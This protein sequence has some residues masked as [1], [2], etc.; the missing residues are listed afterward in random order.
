MTIQER[1]RQVG[2]HEASPILFVSLASLGEAIAGTVHKRRP[3]ESKT[4]QSI[5]VKLLCLSWGLGCQ[6]KLA[7]GLFLGCCQALIR[8][9]G[10]PRENR[11]EQ[12]ALAHIRPS[13]QRQLKSSYAEKPTSLLSFSVPRV[14]SAS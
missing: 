12:R 11:I 10:P 14:S 13:Y 2:F 4:W 1:F 6:G 5:E 7:F 8:G 3:A 9:F